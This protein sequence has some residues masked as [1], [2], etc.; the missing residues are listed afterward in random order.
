MARHIALLLVCGLLVGACG[1]DDE[2]ESRGA[3]NTPQS[4]GTVVPEDTAAAEET[5]GE[6]AGCEKAA[7]PE[8]RE[9]GKLP[10]PKEE[11]DPEKTYVAEIVTSCGE[12]EITLDSEAAPKTGGSFV[13]LA[14]KGFYDGLKFHRIVPGFVIQAGDPRGSGEGGPGYS[15]VEA[16]P[17][18]LVYKKGVVAMA[19]TQLEEPGTSGSQFF[20]VTAEDAGL[21]PEYALL[22]K[23]TKGQEVVARIGVVEVGPDDQPVEPVV[24]QQVKIVE[25]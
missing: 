19:K 23:V 7:D 14:R 13:Y 9:E 4:S 18:D 6:A 17:E 22:G 5:P 1:G 8:A 25:K 24:I 11:L 2:K 3:Q 15:V 21:P 20:V 16:P 10:R 12:F